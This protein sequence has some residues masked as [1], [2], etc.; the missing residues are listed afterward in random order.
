MSVLYTVKAFVLCIGAALIASAAYSQSFEDYLLLNESYCTG[1]GGD[2]SG[3]T[4]SSGSS[5]NYAQ[6]RAEKKYKEE[7]AATM[8]RAKGYERD[9]L[10]WAREIDVNHQQV[11]KLQ[12]H[13]PPTFTQQRTTHF[14]CL[15]NSLIAIVMAADNPDLFSNS[16]D[17]YGHHS[18]T[19]Q[20]HIATF[21]WHLGQFIW[22]TA[23]VQ[24]VESYKPLELE[25]REVQD[26]V[27]AVIIDQLR[28]LPGAL[29]IRLHDYEPT[30]R[31]GIPRQEMIMEQIG[32][33]PR[34]SDYGGV[35]S[36]TYCE[37]PH[38][39][40]RDRV[41]SRQTEAA[42]SELERISRFRLDDLFL[43][44][45][46]F[47]AANITRQEEQ[48]AYEQAT[49]SFLG[50]TARLNSDGPLVLLS[51]DE[52][53][54]AYT[55]T[56]LRAGDII[57]NADNTPVSTLSAL[58]ELANTLKSKGHSSIKLTVKRSGGYSLMTLGI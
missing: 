45:P 20:T 44:V 9:L 34:A 30:E 19:L 41:F 47:G 51:V 38:A 17:F 57:L 39:L 32:F 7:L 33:N 31:L 18:P 46:T 26:A 27:N 49:E 5:R 13:Y 54:H 15:Q 35:F 55:N 14:I 21:Y 3:V 50:M 56:Y 10:N 22:P 40:P 42:M 12:I 23:D 11:R 2:W 24:S 36:E 4:C 8:A 43:D 52:S 53:S 37:F 1:N 16:M 29:R 25:R 48:T 58:R 6:E 28:I